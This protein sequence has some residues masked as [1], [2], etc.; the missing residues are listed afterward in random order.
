MFLTV[1]RSLR[2]EKV[3]LLPRWAYLDSEW[4]ELLDDVFLFAEDK[5][6]YFYYRIV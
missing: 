2:L 1:R 6:V 4:D 5:G 3:L